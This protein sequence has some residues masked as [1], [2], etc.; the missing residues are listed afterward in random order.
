MNEKTTI[1][2]EKTRKQE[3]ERKNGEW[4]KGSKKKEKNRG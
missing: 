3:S 2:L 1:Q 4:K